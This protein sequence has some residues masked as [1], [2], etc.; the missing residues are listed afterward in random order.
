MGMDDAMERSEALWLES[1]EAALAANHTSFAML[2]VSQLLAPD[3]LL[4]RLQA[5]GYSVVVPE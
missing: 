3:G 5:R 4:A 2:P 1:A